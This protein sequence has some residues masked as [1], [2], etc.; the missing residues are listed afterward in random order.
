MLDKEIKVTWIEEKH[1]TVPM[2]Y[3][4]CAI[5][6]DWAAC[7]KAKQKSKIRHTG[8]IIDFVTNILGTTKAI[9]DSGDNK[10][11]KVPINKLTVIHK[12]KKK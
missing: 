4:E 2:E 9:I 7:E 11:V 1:I 5:K 3:T 12:P 6:E 10:I 8:V